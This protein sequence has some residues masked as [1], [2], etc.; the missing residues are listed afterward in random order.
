MKHTDGRTNNGGKRD[1]A[2]RPKMHKDP[3]VIG[4]RLERETKNALRDKFGKTLAQ[5]FAQW[6]DDLL[7]EEKP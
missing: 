1:G 4:F 7:M 5:R 6:A 2:G 3:V